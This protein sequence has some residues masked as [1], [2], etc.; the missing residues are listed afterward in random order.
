MPIYK[1][2]K[3]YWVDISAPDGSRIRRSAGTEDKKKAQ[4]YHDKIKHELWNINKLDKRPDHSFD[5]IILLAMK[6]AE[7]Q[8]LYETKKAYAK[9]WLSVFKGRSVS[10]IKGDEIARMMPTHSLHKSRKPLANGTVNRYRA[11]IVRA[12]SLAFKHGW[13]E[14][15]PYVP[16][17]RE[18]KVRVRW[19][20]KWQ[21]RELIDGLSTDIMRR[22]VSFALLT[23]ARRGEILSLTWENVDIENRNAV[24][25]AE[26][27]KSGRARSLPLHDE[28]ISI[29][30]E[31]EKTCDFVFSVN[32]EKLSDIDR[33]DFEQATT[34]ANLTDFRFHDLRHTWASWHV[35]N[36]TPLMI[37]KEMGGWETLEMVKKY[38]HLSAEHLNK[39]VGSVTFLAQEN[40]IEALRSR[41][42]AANY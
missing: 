5:D 21:A 23:G 30:R 24:V 6:D 16:S 36:G 42:N 9:Y 8:A 15:R 26:N 20:R 41:K 18:P 28:A 31:C 33:K 1:R 19:I 13:I 7:D 12:L 11:F 25:T 29:L 39:F 27:A 37:L 4:Q 3:N 32:G 35:Q 40:E 34:R 38:A 17:L 14:H 10:S 22:I 2:G